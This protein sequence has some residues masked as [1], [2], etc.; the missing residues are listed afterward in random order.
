MADLLECVIQIKALGASLGIA[1]RA[2]SAG[3]SPGMDRAAFSA[4]WRRMADAERRY[5]VALGTEAKGR[6]NITSE[7]RGAAD[8]AEVFAAMRRA[9]LAM[10]EGCTAA[11]LAGCIEW[12]GRPSTTV[13]DLV[14][15][16]LASDTEVLGDVRRARSNP[17]PQLPPAAP[18]P[19]DTPGRRREP[20]A[21]T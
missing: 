14:A 9:N 15:I 13:A 3:S 20:P 2:M 5:A 10:L 21:P 17:W 6:P 4:V 12:P 7:S 16:M 18:K 11:R 8:S 19:I 1:A